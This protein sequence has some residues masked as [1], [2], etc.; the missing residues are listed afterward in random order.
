MSLSVPSS[1]AVRAFSDPL[2][3]VPAPRALRPKAAA[4]P[5]AA[6]TPLPAQPPQK[7]P[8][9][10][11][12]WKDRL[13]NAAR[14]VASAA[15]GASIAGLGGACAAIVVSALAPVVQDMGGRLMQ[16]DGQSASAGAAERM[17]NRH[18]MMRRM[19][20]EYSTQPAKD[21]VSGRSS[22]GRP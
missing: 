15:V 6:A 4:A 12:S 1:L 16:L 21:R 5:A 17:D 13:A 10:R 14:T 8:E 3:T 7:A 19:G 11:T 22:P 18:K 9:P 20:E 2:P